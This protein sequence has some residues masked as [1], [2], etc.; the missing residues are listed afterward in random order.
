[1]TQFSKMFEIALAALSLMDMTWTVTR[2]GVEKGGGRWVQAQ[3]FFLVPK[4]NFISIPGFV[5]RKAAAW[6]MGLL[7]GTCKSR[8]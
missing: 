7:H 2:K 8:C 3:N 1:M 6:R 4:L 5:L